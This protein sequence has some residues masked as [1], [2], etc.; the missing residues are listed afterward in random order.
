MSFVVVGLSHR[1]A[2]VDVLERFTVAGED[3]AKALASMARTEHVN[4]AVLISTCNRTEAYV[5]AEK[6][7]G[8]FEDV[9]DLL[10]GIADTSA[11]RLSDHLFVRYDDEA[12]RHLFAVSAGLDSAVVGEHEI[13]GQ[14]R[15]AWQAAQAEGTAGSTCNLV[16]RHALEVGKRARNETGISRGTA[17][18]SHA[19]VE[20]AVERLG[21]LT[22]KSVLVLGAGEMGEGMVTALSG[23]GVSSIRVANRTRAR[24]EQLAERVDGVAIDLTDLPI[25]LTEVDVLLTSTGAT[26]LLVG[27]ADLAAAVA[28]RS[29]R[30]MLV[31]DV[32]VPRDVDPAVSDLEGVTLLDMDDLHDFALVGL[33]SRRA[34]VDTVGTI[35]DE[36]VARFAGLRTAR[37]VAPLIGELHQRADD[38]RQGELSRYASRLAELGPEEREAVEALTKAIVAKMLHQPTVELKTAAGSS[39]GQRLAE[40][41]RALFEL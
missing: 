10:A 38:I 11:D 39:R 17:S 21:D 29:G 28:R 20:M 31:V 40:S 22:D 1:T 15:T 6:F 33:A 27:H 23:A 30:P 26:S 3:L 4:E 7:H 37:E 14:V 19:A 35:I 34:E 18:V 5:A 32:A 36:E 8:A 2:P 9:R 25:A 16:F 24:A 41:A 13:L 12:V